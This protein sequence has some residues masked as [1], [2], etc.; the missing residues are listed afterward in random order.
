MQLVVISGLVWNSNS[1]THVKCML[2][3]GA[4]L[5]HSMVKKTYHAIQQSSYML[6]NLAVTAILCT[7]QY[8]ACSVAHQHG[9]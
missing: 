3:A 5:L 2:P 8:L 1:R 7:R 9:V 6:T 4:V